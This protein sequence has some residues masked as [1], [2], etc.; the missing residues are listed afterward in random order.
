[1]SSS[2][3][4]SASKS[5]SSLVL[6]ILNGLLILASDATGIDSDFLPNDC[7]SCS[8]ISVTSVSELSESSITVGCLGSEDSL[9]TGADCVGVGVCCSAAVLKGLTN[10]LGVVSIGGDWVLAGEIVGGD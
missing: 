10:G 7:L 8:A 9:S 4:G 5:S 1:V 3:D 6:G 2:K